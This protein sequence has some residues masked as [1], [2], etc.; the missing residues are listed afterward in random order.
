M[1]S[2]QFAKVDCESEA[3]KAECDEAG[4]KNAG[5]WV[6]TSTPHEGIQNYHG[7]RTTPKLIEHIRYKFMPSDDADVIPFENENAFYERLDKGDKPKPIIVKFWESWCTHCKAAKIPFEQAAGF[8]KEQVEFME[9]ECSKND[10]TKKFCQANG[11][12]GYPTII[13]FDGEQKHKYEMP[14]KSIGSF[15][16]FFLTKLPAE[17]YTMVE[18]KEAAELPPVPGA[19]ASS[20]NDKSRP[21]ASSKKDK[22]AKKDDKKKD[23]KKSKKR[24]DDDDE[25]DKPRRRRSRRSRR[26]RRR[27]DDEEDDD[28]EPRRKRKSSRRRRR[29]DDDDE[30]DEPRRRR[31]RRSRRRDEDEDDEDDQPRRK[32]NNSRRRRDGDDGDKPK[33]KKKKNNNKNADKKTKD[34]KKDEKKAPVHDEL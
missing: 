11:V 25:D 28:D 33:K 8:F 2:F 15:Q 9:V 19:A 18:D 5:I 30:D 4:F 17:T 7:P 34:D 6:F 22:A 27:D 1:N 20:T 21:A 26:S 29:D 10:E 23:T 31:S 14:D 24:S 3:N 32:R 16:E 13:L 12:Q